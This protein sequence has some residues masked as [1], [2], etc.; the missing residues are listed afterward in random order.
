MK[1]ASEEGLGNYSTRSRSPFDQAIPPSLVSKL[2]QQATASMQSI[3]MHQSSQR[4]SLQ[5]SPSTTDSAVEE[6]PA[7][8]KLIWSFDVIAILEP[9][10][11]VRLDARLPAKPTGLGTLGLLATRR[12]RTTKLWRPFPSKNSH[13][14]CL[15]KLGWKLL[16]N[17]YPSTTPCAV[18]FLL[19]PTHAEAAR[20]RKC[21]DS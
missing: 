1:S 21:M 18:L 14:P 12:N 10:A 19:V 2:Q 13:Q 16:G 3:Y 8:V 9:S 6:R 15:N 20:Y 17:T 11:I 5:S 7:K 4:L